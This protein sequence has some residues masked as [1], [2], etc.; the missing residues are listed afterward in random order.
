MTELFEHQKTGIAFL[1]RTRK[2]I[3]ADEM[4]LG[5]T[6]QAIVSA[7]DQKGGVLI[8]CPA[9][10]KINWKREIHMVYPGDVVQVVEGGKSAEPKS[11][12]ERHSP[13]WIVINYDIIAKHDWI[14]ELV[15]KGE[16][17]TVILDEAHYIK[18]KTTIRSR[19]TLAIAHDAQR[20][21]CLTGTPV[22]NRPI[23]IFNMLV[24]IRHPLA[25]DRKFFVRRY[26]GGQVK[27]LIRDLQEGKSF[28]VSD[29]GQ[30]GFKRPRY[31]WFRF[32]DETGAINLEELRE[33]I[34]ESVLRRTKKEVLDLPEK[35]VSEVEYELKPE[36]RHAYV[37]AWDDYIE[38]LEKNPDSEKN[39][40]DIK[41]AQ[42]LVEIGKL[43]QVCSL[44]KCSRVIADIKNIVEQDEKVI[45]FT[46][47]RNTL[48][49]LENMLEEA[50]ISYRSLE[51]ST[52]LNDRQRYVDDFQNGKA[53]VFLANIKAGGV[54]ITLTA[55]TIVIFVDADWSPAVNE[56]AED[57]AHR[58]GQEGTVNVYYYVTKDTI[59]EEIQQILREKKDIIGRLVEGS[60][61]QQDTIA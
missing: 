53:Q 58:I 39:I 37:R 56:Q 43:K 7:G 12:Y 60:S 57:R 9:S 6:R 40:K 29:G 10:L 51:G 31:S 5:K 36:Q 61:Y 47:Y 44:A 8:V 48:L 14:A 11:M 41:S 1:N 19:A 55:A 35:I 46:Q 32:R 3:L 18:G 13:A 17:E 23:E 50:D 49:R 2:A 25:K 22:M 33:Y 4:G 52:K 21:Y 38:W 59:E 15:E 45:V 34:K 30:W 24:A 26:C 20:V 54:G 42:Q 16:I 28:F 27:V